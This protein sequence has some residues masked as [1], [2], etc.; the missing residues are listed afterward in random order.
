[1]QNSWRTFARCGKIDEKHVADVRLKK[2][3]HFF[4]SECWSSLLTNCDSKT[5]RSLV[6]SEEGKTALLREISTWLWSCFLCSKLVMVWK[7]LGE[8]L[9]KFMLKI[10]NKAVFPFL[11]KTGE[12]FCLDLKKITSWKS[13]NFPVH[14][15]TPSSKRMTQ[16]ATSYCKLYVSSFTAE[17]LPRAHILTYF[18]SLFSLLMQINLPRW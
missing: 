4:A 13:V 12:E 18:L 11:W 10:K 15:F 16:L 14:W 6:E 7:S 8:V 3:T 2:L 1:M 17:N 5:R 9:T